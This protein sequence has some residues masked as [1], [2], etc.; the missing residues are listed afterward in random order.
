MSNTSPLYSEE[1]AKMYEAYVTC[2][3][4]VN[5]KFQGL[6]FEPKCGAERSE[7]DSQLD[8]S[9][10]DVE[11]EVP[12]GWEPPKSRVRDVTEPTTSTETGGCSTG[13]LT[14][15]GVALSLLGLRRRRA[16]ARNPEAR[17]LCQPS[18]DRAS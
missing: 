13:G 8:E 14:G 10:M 15:L 1:R 12:R 16:I 17:A 2:P 5:M 18:A 4:D 9:I 7:S 6:N 11:F 3:A